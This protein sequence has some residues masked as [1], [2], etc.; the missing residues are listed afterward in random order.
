MDS[1][2][3]AKLAQSGPVS[4]YPASPNGDILNN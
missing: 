3:V 4:P 2:E 1:R